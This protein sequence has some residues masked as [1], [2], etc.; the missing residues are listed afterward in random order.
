MASS[1]VPAD[2][3]VSVLRLLDAAADE[4]AD[5][6]AM[7]VRA[8]SVNGDEGAGA[9]VFSDWFERNGFAA[10]TK[11]VDSAFRD[12]FPLLAN[13]VDLERRPNVFGWWRSAR[14]K[15]PPLVLNGHYDVIPAGDPA[16]WRHPPFGGNRV[17]GRI[18]GRGATDM[19]GPLVAGMFALR[20]L[21][22][23]GA[24]LP[25]DVQVQCVMGEES[26]GLGT[27]AAIASE[28]QPSAAV[29]LEPTEL[30]VA[31]CCGGLVQ[32]AIG[33]EGQAIHTA[34]PWRGV[35]ALDK[36]IIVYERLRDLATS[37]NSTLSHPLFDQLPMK[38]PFAVGTFHAGKWRATVPDSAVMEGRIGLLPGEERADVRKLVEDTI[39]E[40]AAADE[41]LAAHPPHVRWINE[42]FPA[43]ETPV[44]HPI[45]QSFIAAYQAVGKQAPVSAVT[46]GTDAA[47]FAAAGVPVLIF[48]PGSIVD[49]HQVDESIAEAALVLGA[50]IVALGVLRYAEV[51]ERDVRSTYPY[52]PSPSPL[53]Q[54]G[55]E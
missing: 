13:E 8:E 16:E 7:S 46:F 37:R 1:L 11:T 32:F 14:A 34:S 26:G 52:P 19:K 20:A 47:H 12:Q 10:E 17:G 35:S 54:R 2:L 39:A 9:A 50:K 45:V 42:G 31:P 53:R 24:Q 43:W 23:A 4:L 29:V 49:A 30:V 27:L 22:D 3:E 28:P 18:Y 40:V 33:V 48:G 21:R 55:S 51:A 15:V 44:E 41:W 6:V 36:L 25:F 38:A 5:D